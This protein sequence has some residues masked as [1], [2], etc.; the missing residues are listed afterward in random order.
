MKRSPLFFCVCVKHHRFR[1]DYFVVVVMVVVAVVVYCLP[2][3]VT[4]L[5]LYILTVL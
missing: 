1:E 3:G 2:Y 4:R 5:S